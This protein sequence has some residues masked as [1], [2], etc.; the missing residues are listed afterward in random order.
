MRLHIDSFEICNL[1][2]DVNMESGVLGEIIQKIDEKPA[3]ILKHNCEYILKINI[4][5]K[6][7]KSKFFTGLFHS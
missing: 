1:F 3:R 2:L 7:S 5:V 6:N 4:S